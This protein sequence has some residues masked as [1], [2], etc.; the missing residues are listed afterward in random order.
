MPPI[1]RPAND[2]VSTVSTLGRLIARLALDEA[3][4]R[5]YTKDEA[6][7]EAV[8]ERSGL[9]AEETAALKAGDWTEILELLGPKGRGTDAHRDIDD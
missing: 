5:E 6:G 7:A 8:M 1:V 3:L 2:I 4:H 9:S